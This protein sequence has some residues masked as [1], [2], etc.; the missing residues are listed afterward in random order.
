MTFKAKGRVSQV[1][2]DTP[3]KSKGPMKKLARAGKTTGL[4]VGGAA[5]AAIATCEISAYEFNERT[6]N[7]PCDRLRLPDVP[8]A[9]ELEENLCVSVS[10]EQPSKIGVERRVLRD[11]KV[12]ITLIPEW[13]YDGVTEWVRKSG[14]DA[15]PVTLITGA[16]GTPIHVD[17]RSHWRVGRCDATEL[18]DAYGKARIVFA[19]A[20]HTPVV[21]GC[22]PEVHNADEH[23]SFL[24]NVV[25][26]T[27]YRY[28]MAVGNLFF[29]SLSP[30][31]AAERNEV[32]GENHPARTQSFFVEDRI[33]E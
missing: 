21:A 16:D 20:F 11:G 6:A 8:G 26:R 15:E 33:D 1:P 31:R 14:P 3:K 22:S 25:F 7:V 18:V 10:G 27:V 30:L 13:N 24:N 32:P 28:A 9:D 2:A 12:A 4:I 23:G 19:N 29:G 5:V 17:I